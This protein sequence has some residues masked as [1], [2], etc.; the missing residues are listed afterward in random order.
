M[1]GKWQLSVTQ[2]H[3]FDN[4]TKLL[5]GFQQEAHPHSLF[6]GNVNINTV[7][8]RF[9]SAQMKKTL[10]HDSP[11]SP[12]ADYSMHST[13]RRRSHITTFRRKLHHEVRRQ[14]H[15]E[16]RLQL[17]LT[18]RRHSLDVFQ[19]GSGF[20]IISPQPQQPP[21]I[22]TTS[23]PHDDLSPSTIKPTESHATEGP[24]HRDA[25]P[26]CLRVPSTNGLRTRAAFNKHSELIPGTEI[27]SSQLSS[28]TH[29]T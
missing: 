3:S 24:L 13:V 19:D 25:S 22:S 16:V 2:N 15:H 20:A 1:P 4:S 26:Q 28:G 7:G 27:S 8:S 6:L 14:S 10:W 9:S 17:Q 5:E 11:F 29:S 23:T 12:F 18:F 21:S